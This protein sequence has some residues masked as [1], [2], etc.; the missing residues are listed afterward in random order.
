MYSPQVR[1]ID[2]VSGVSI[3]GQQWANRPSLL[4]VAGALGSIETIL[5]ATSM[6]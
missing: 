2:I 6:W 3:G 5:D 4:K 1:Q